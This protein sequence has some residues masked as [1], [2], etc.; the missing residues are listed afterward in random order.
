MICLLLSITAC[1]GNSNQE[2]DIEKRGEKTCRTDHVSNT[3][4]GSIIYDSFIKCQDYKQLKQLGFSPCH[5]M[6]NK[7]EKIQENISIEKIEDISFAY[8]NFT[9]N[10]KDIIMVAS[11][12]T[13]VFDFDM[14]L[15]FPNYTGEVV[16]DVM[17]QEKTLNYQ[18]VDLDGDGIS[19]IVVECLGVNKSRKHVGI[20]RYEKEIVPIFEKNVDSYQ[21][22]ISYKIIKEQLTMRETKY[23]YNKSGKKK[24]AEVVEYEYV[25]DDTKMEQI[26][27][28]KL[29]ESKLEDFKAWTLG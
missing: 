21:Y 11:V 12:K 17:A 6:E 2:N 26:S 8:C 18:L 3:S 14:M 16:F 10:N 7:I 4:N 23:Y 28:R 25:Y 22:D 24:K 27:K 15:L 5:A 19:E 1:T 9:G 13:N 20:Y 29:W